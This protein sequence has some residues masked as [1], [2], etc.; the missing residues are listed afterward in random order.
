MKAQLLKHAWLQFSR[1]PALTRNIIQTILIGF[2]AL[3]FVLLMIGAA[4]ALRPILEDMLPGQDLLLVVG[5]LLGY[6]FVMDILMRYFIQKFPSL[7]VKPYLPLPFKKS[8]LSHYVLFW[9]LGSFFNLLPLFFLVPFFFKEI[10]PAYPAE[11]LNFALFSIGMVLFNNYL[12]LGISKYMAARSSWAGILI[13]G[14]MLLFFLE[15]QGSFSLFDYLKNGVAVVLASPL[16]SAIPLL[17]TGGIYLFLHRFFKEELYLE[18][19]Q[20][21]QNLVGA[22]LSIGWFDR[23]GDAGKLMDLELKLILRSKRARAYLIT[24][25]LFVLYPLFFLSMGEDAVSSPYILLM[26]GLFLTGMVG[27]NHGQILLSWNSLHFDL[28]MS[29]GN[30]IHDIF[31]AKYYFLALACILFFAISIPYVL[32]NPKILLYSV[33]MLLYN[34]AFSLFG[35]L[36]LASYTALRVDPNE[37]GAFS[38]DGFGIAHYLI[39]FPIMALPFLLYLGGSTVGGEMGGLLA[40]LLPSILMLIFYKSLL[41]SVVNNFRNHRHKIA[42]AFRKG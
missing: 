32:L 9:S 29:R 28:L 42:A 6:Y 2:F 40:I 30:T 1:S 21:Q 33:V 4:V 26:V 18:K 41:N 37:G 7:V 25:G 38:F 36:F 8:S 5:G 20:S 27:I 13:I 10:L 16:L 22:N 24:S 11:A 23:F 3:Y 39:I 15:Y 12:S 35:Y 31:K 14:V 34:L 17:L 19:T